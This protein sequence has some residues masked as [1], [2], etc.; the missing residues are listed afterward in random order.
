[1]T[2][3][4]SKSGTNRSLLWR[5]WPKE[6]VVA[7]RLAATI[8]IDWCVL[9]TLGVRC[10]EVE[11]GWEV[12]GIGGRFQPGAPWIWAMVEPS[13]FHVGGRDPLCRAGHHRWISTIA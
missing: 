1:M 5:P 12:H 13:S 7:G 9:Q 8:A 6:M 11:H 4:G 10:L 2:V 3:P